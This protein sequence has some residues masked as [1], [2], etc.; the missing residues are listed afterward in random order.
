MA[1]VAQ[2]QIVAM[3]AP[4]SSQP[5]SSVTPP[6]FDQGRTYFAQV[7]GGE[8]Q[9]TVEKV[10]DGGS[11]TPEALPAPI[12]VGDLTVTRHYDA[13]MDGP[14]INQVRP[15]V[16]KA[17]YDVTVVTLD[18]DNNPIQGVSRLYPRTLLVNVSE[19]EGDSSSGGPATFSMTFSCENIV[20]S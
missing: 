18:P 4:S 3:V 16:G 5:N 2:R 9:A 12:E 19:S 8:V 20:A 7:S 13:A 6:R 10:Y 17:R 1:K 11:T 14:L 15:L